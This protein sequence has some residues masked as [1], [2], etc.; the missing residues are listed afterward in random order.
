MRNDKREGASWIALIALD[1]SKTSFL[2]T[3]TNSFGLKP[4]WDAIARIS[5]LFGSITTIAPRLQLFAST[6]LQTR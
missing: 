2:T 6:F 4:G 3:G 1:R 5:P